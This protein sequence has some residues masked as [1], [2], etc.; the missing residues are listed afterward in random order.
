MST[1]KI[2]YFCVWMFIFYNFPQVK[3]E[4]FCYDFKDFLLDV[5]ILGKVKLNIERTLLIKSTSNI[6]FDRV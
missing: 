4:M 2:T 5:Q 1:F 3:K 6:H